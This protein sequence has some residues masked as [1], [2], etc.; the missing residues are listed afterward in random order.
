MTDLREG[1]RDYL[2]LR[3]GLGF[4]LRGVAHCLRN[5][6]TFAEEEG[7]SYITTELALRWVR[8]RDVQ[9]ATMSARLG[10][11][12]RF[13]AYRIADDP[14]TEVPPAGLLP[15]RYRR[16]PPYIY[17]DS[18]VDK[19]I[20]AAAELPSKR[21][22]RG[23][24]CATMFGLVAVTGMRMGEALALDREDVDLDNGLVT[25]RRSKF[26][27][28]RLVPLHDATRLALAAYANHRD[29]SFSTPMTRSFFVSDRGTRFKGCTARYNFAR[30]SQRLGL[31]PPAEGRRHGHGPR[32]HDLRHR[33]A[34]KTMIDWYRAGRD[35]E[36]ELP[37]LTTYLGHVHVADTYWYLE[38]VPELLELATQRLIDRHEQATP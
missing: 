23:K 21:G 27:K 17:S 36:R 30:L 34:V 37:K 15:Y 1:L 19:I 7:A 9:A 26:G 8:S 12:R 33:F 6:I 3:R 14:R 28:S 31:R 38:A 11:V 32:L 18:E 24:T 29:E 22:F 25:I 35:V 5:F 2:A 13:A 16:K 4:E 10:M 20:E